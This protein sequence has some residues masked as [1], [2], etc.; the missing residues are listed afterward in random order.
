[1][2]LKSLIRGSLRARLI[3]SFAVAILVPA[4]ITTIV[5]V[6]TI[7]KHVYGQAQSKINS[8]LESAK[9]IYASALDR[10]KDTLRI[11]ATRM[12]LYRALSTGDTAELGPE[13]ERIR[14]EE[15]LDVLTLVDDRG[16]VVF[17]AANPGLTGDSLEGD[18]TVQEVLARKSPVASTEV[19]PDDALRRESEALARQAAMDLAPTPH[20][21]PTDQKRLTAGLMLKGGAPVFT[22]SKR[23]LGVLCGEVL[24]N[25]NYALVDKVRTVVFKDAFYRGRETGT[26]TIFQGDVRVST[27]VKGADGARAIATRVSAEVAEEVLERGGI[28]RGRAFVVND[29]Y[30][31]AY[32]PLKDLREKTV[33]ILYVG[34][35]ETPYKDSLRRSLAVFLGIAA[36]GVV[37]LIL[38]ATRVSQRIARPIADMARAAG[39]VATGDYTQTV[40]VRGTDEIAHLSH[41]FN[42]MVAELRDTNHALKGWTET[43]EQRVEQRTAELKAMQ[44]QLFQTEKLAAVGKLAAGVAHE[45]NNPLTGILTNAS[46]MLEDLSADDPRRADLQTIVDETLRCRKI[47]KGL[48]DFARQTPPQKTAASLNKVVEDILSL[49]RNQASF[50]NIAIRTDLDP[51][52]P[53]VMTDQDQMRQVV[54]NIILNASEAMAEKGELHISSR[55]DPQRGRVEIS[56]RDTGPGIPD[57]IKGKLFEPFFTTKATGTGLG[58][59]IAY[60][61]MERHG[62]EIRLDSRVGRGTT[63][64]LALPE[65]PHER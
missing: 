64:T 44:A 42:R 47:V 2:T 58:L 30:L 7:K 53:A 46:L 34:L 49:V 9:E 48:L 26:V 39:E 38:V 37:L 51:D 12:I 31:S 32:A 27:N 23:F 61:I 40:V 41:A 54:L 65:E 20:A 16:I 10:L 63:I 18:P 28:W 50:R 14:A 60:G 25:R 33:G 29:W 56:F 11:H 36:L 52:L 6:Q 59:A 5:G 1:M 22:P 13:L 8:D 43:L 17:R 55:R 57:D 35:L 3:V 21:R 15:G 45:I 62:G 19:V 4:L 24:L